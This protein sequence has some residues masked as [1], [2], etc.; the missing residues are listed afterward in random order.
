M[1]DVRVR[2]SNRA[3]TETVFH[4]LMHWKPA[5]VAIFLAVDLLLQISWHGESPVPSFTQFVAAF[6]VGYTSRRALHDH[7]LREGRSLVPGVMGLHVR[8]TVIGVLVALL[9]TIAASIVVSD[10][11]WAWIAIV[12]FGLLCGL[13]TTTVHAPSGR[14]PLA[15]LVL[16][17]AALAFDQMSESPTHPLTVALGEPLSL[18]PWGV[19]S[20]LACALVVRGVVRSEDRESW[21]RGPATSNTTCSAHEADAEMKWWIAIFPWLRRRPPA[22]T[23]RASLPT[24]QQAS[25]LWRAGSSSYL[26][27]A[28]GLLNGVVLSALSITAVLA[29][30]TIELMRDGMPVYMT[31]IGI[32]AVSSNFSRER[33]A[34]EALR[35]VSRSGL[36]AGF[37]RAFALDGL[38]ATVG[39]LALTLAVHAVLDRPAVADPRYWQAYA[40]LPGMILMTGALTWIVLRWWRLGG[41]V[42]IA[43]AGAIA[44]VTNESVADATTVEGW[45]RPAL[46]VLVAGLILVAIAARVWRDVEFERGSSHTRER[47]RSRPD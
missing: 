13:L 45:L 11:P 14:A 25:E 37:A 23:P 31:L 34:M 28:V 10:R 43:P 30:K 38:Q 29:G 16:A 46:V 3:V 1:T 7:V 4:A 20:L 21:M 27:V 42:G 44:L 35:P 8:I 2:T 18:I 32:I 22:F 19:A 39:T 33:M 40:L 6:L 5:L 41:V 24:W 26:P 36:H 9:P 17:G 47:G 15:I 12:P